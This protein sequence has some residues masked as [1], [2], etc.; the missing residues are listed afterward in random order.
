[1]ERVP[2]DVLERVFFRLPLLDVARSLSVCKRWQCLLSSPHFILHYSKSAENSNS[3]VLLTDYNGTA[4]PHNSRLVHFYDPHL[5]KSLKVDLSFLP[6]ELTIPVASS[7]GLLCVSAHNTNLLCTCN[8]LTKAYKILPSPNTLPFLSLTLI[9]EGPVFESHKILVISDDLQTMYSPEENR[10]IDLASQ[11]RRPKSAVTVSNGFL[12][13]FEDVGSDWHPRWTLVCCN[14]NEGL[15]LWE[16]VRHNWEDMYDII[17]EPCLIRG[18]EGFL[19]MAGGLKA[20]LSLNSAC[21]AFVIMELDLKSLE[22]NEA[23]RMPAEFYECFDPQGQFSIFGGKEGVYFSGRKVG[24][25]VLWDAGKGCW[26]WVDCASI[27]SGNAFFRGFAFDPR[28]D[29]VP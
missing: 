14:I 13:G 3:W 4:L 27:E 25:L 6:I 18:R 24:R 26:Q 12:F 19:F 23:G 9:L 8:P 29:A 1:M 20:S 2:G 16:P 7:Q 22:W 11:G 15:L 5:H 10:W 17:K 21:S 28:L